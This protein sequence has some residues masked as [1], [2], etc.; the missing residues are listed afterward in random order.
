MIALLA[1]LAIVGAV[2]WHS[3]EAARAC[4]KGLWALIDV[5]F[6]VAVFLGVFVINGWTFACIALEAVR[7]KKRES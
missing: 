1:V 3:S 5:A 6:Q 4:K 2:C 7:A